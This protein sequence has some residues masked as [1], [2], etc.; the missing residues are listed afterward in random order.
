MCNNN[1]HCRKFDAGTMC[2]SYRATLDEAHLTR[3][4]ANT[5]RLALSGQLGAESDQAVAQALDLC[6]SCKGCK[7]ECPTGVDMARMKIEFLAHYKARRGYSLRDRAIAYLPRYAP[8]AARLASA[9]N[10]LA[11]ALKGAVGFSARRELPQWRGDYFVDRTRPI[12][13]AGREVLV[14]VDTFNRWFEP[15]NARAAIRVLQAAGYKVA[16]AQPL[17]HGRPLC[18]GRTFL[19]AGMVEEARTEAR[20]TLEALRPYAA[21]GVPII[22]L[23]PSCLLSFRDEYGVLLEGS[24]GVAQNS[25]LF[26]EFIAREPGDLRFKELP[27]DVLLHGH[28]HQKAF[29]VMP[30]VHK[31]LAMVPG[32]KVS[33]VQASCCGMAGSFG[34]EAEHYPASMKMAELDL[35]PTI[36]ANPE[37]LLVADGTSCRHQIADGAGREA[38]HVARVLETALNVP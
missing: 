33:T 10:R 26:E 24:D 14:F 8:W 18:C 27:R 12:R 3:G 37:A 15:H 1:G 6:V 34:Y 29:D 13:G 31:V 4:R 36:R 25:F 30:A 21:R 23:E 32:L 19:A 28:C 35:L 2:P 16:A 7:R 22:G 17:L 9:S 5:L 11:E 20:R 38:W